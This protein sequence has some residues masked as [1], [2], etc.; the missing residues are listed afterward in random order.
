M[1][2]LNGSGEF[3]TILRFQKDNGDEG[4]GEIECFHD[5]EPRRWLNANRVNVGAVGPV[6]ALPV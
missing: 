2:T 1:K 5:E 3:L 4:A 6:D